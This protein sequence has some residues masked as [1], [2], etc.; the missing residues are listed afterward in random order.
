[1]A[2]RKLIDYLRDFNR[3]ERFILLDHVLGQQPGDVFRLNRYFAGKL[4]TELSLEIPVD[5]FVAMDYH[6]DWIQMAL[7]LADRPGSDMRKTICNTGKRLVKANQEDVDLLVAFEDKGSQKTHLLLIEAKADTGWTNK[8]LRSKARRLEHIFN[9]RILEVV[10]PHFV[11][12]SRSRPTDKLKTE[13]WPSWMKGNGNAV[14][15]WLEL[16]LRDGLLKVT[17]CDQDGN[18]NKGGRYLLV[19]Q[20]KDGTWTSASPNPPT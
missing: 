1:M 6:L 16:P 11:L 4:A 14:A 7:Y 12:M 9:D 18:S 3:K 15:H 10:E 13:K 2:E 19:R 5:A 17:R 8:Q 20:R